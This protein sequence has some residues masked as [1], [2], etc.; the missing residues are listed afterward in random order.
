MQIILLILFIITSV[1]HL[2]GEFKENLTLRYISKP[3]LMPLLGLYYIIGNPAVNFWVVAGLIGGFLGDVLLMI[4]DPK[5]TQKYFMFGLI[6]FLL[7]HLFYIIA[8]I[9]LA[10]NFSQFP[11]WGLILALPFVIYGIIAYSKLMPYMDQNAPEMKLPV[12]V[13][14]FVIMTMGVSTV[15]PLG[16]SSTL[17]FILSMIGA[18]SFIISDTIIAFNKFGPKI[19]NDRI[20]TM[21]TYIAGQ[22]LIV[23]GFMLA[24]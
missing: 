11:L 10:G 7:G 22:F 9:L 23:I 12:T 20:Y 8:F 16:Y 5:N 18:Y 6:S 2:I 19:K 21:S 24:A 13:Y 3:L 17:G 1:I 15:F 4:P 14:L